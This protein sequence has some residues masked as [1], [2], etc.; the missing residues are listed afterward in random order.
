MTVW[1]DQ[2]VADV[3]GHG[4][5]GAVVATVANPAGQL[6][7]RGAIRVVVDRRRL[8]NRIGVDGQHTGRRDSTVSATAFSDAHCTP[9]TSRTA[10]TRAG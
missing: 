3:L 9:E 10:V 6:R 8:R 2:R 5:A 1:L 4:L 7:H